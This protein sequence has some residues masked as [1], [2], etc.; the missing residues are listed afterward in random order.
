MRYSEPQKVW[1]LTGITSY[2][3]GCALPD[4]AG[5]YTRVS[6]YIDWIESI[7]GNDG[8]VTISQNNANIGSMSSL[9][10]FSLIS[11]LIVIRLY[12]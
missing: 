8:L 10:L 9:I 11:F 5:V 12:N 7:V 2:G 1:V 6:K 3:V 4:Y